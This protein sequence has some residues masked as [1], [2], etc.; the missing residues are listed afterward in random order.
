MFKE[1]SKKKGVY[2]KSVT[3]TLYRNRFLV[4]ECILKLVCHLERCRLSNIGYAKE[5]SLKIFEQIVTDTYL[6]KQSL[7]K[8][9]FLKI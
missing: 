1:E 7:Q 9:V 5:I 8:K 3:K 4:S 2:S 6:K